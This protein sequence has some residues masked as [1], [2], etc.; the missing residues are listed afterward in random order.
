M[1]YNVK[2]TSSAES[3]LDGIIAYIIE[4]LCNP[5]AANHLLNE[6]EKV[7][8]ELAVTPLCYPSC[9]QPLLHRYRKAAIMRYVMIYRVDEDTVYVERFF[10]QLE[11][12]ANKL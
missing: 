8:K 1:D 2:V 10:S 11:D 5:Q 4:E 7:Y 6:I 9:A 3:D 12:Y